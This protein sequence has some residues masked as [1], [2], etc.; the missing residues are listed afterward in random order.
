MRDINEHTP[1]EDLIIKAAVRMLVPFAQLFGLYVVV[2]GHYSPGG[3]FQGGVILGAAFI[4]LAL[5]F[6]M[7]TSQQYM[8]IGVNAAF[9]NLGAAIFVGVGV[10]CALF[11]G[12]F[13]DY[14]ALDKLIPLGPVEWRSFGIFLVEVGVGF[15]VMSIMVL[16]YWNLSSAGSMEEGL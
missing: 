6:D 1:G 2:H 11:G 16:L 14:S 15:T 12:L 5:A 13:L 3:G 10:L 8:T 7:K 4:M 9:N